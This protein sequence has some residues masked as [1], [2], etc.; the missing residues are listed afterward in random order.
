MKNKYVLGLNGLREAYPKIVTAL[1]QSTFTRGDDFEPMYIGK[2]GTNSPI[3]RTL[4]TSKRD[5]MLVTDIVIDLGEGEE[6]YWLLLDHFTHHKHDRHPLL[7][8]KILLDHLQK[9]MPE[10]IAQAELFKSEEVELVLPSSIL[11]PPP[12][13][14]TIAGIAANLLTIHAVPA[15]T[16][17]DHD[18]KQTGSEVVDEEKIEEIEFEYFNNQFIK[19]NQKQLAA[20]QSSEQRLIVNG[21]PGT[22]KSC[23]AIAKLTQAL[24]NLNDEI[25]FTNYL[26][27]KQTS[28]ILYVTA[29]E[30]LK[31]NM[32][33]MRET[34]P[35]FSDADDNKIEFMTYE[36]FLH[37]LNP[38]LAKKTVPDKDCFATWLKKY[39]ILHSSHKDQLTECLMKDSDLTNALWEEFRIISN[40]EKSEYQKIGSRQSIFSTVHLSKPLEIKF[41]DELFQLLND[42]RNFLKSTNQFDP[43]FYS[44]EA[45]PK[46]Y[47]VVVDEAQDFSTIQLA[48]LARSANR[49]TFFCDPNQSL[50]DSLSNLSQLKKILG[51]NVTNIELSE[52]LRC[53]ERVVQVANA[54]LEMKYKVTGGKQDKET[55]SKIT[56]SAN[57]K[58]GNT[59]IY[60][61][62]TLKEQVDMMT[63][64]K[65]VKC[66]VITHPEFIKDAQRKFPNAQILTVEQAK[67]LEFETVICF[68]L[69]EQ[70]RYLQIN[71]LL[72]DYQADAPA[73]Q[74]RAKN[75]HHE[76]GPAF[77]S[78]FTAFTRARTSLII[79]NDIETNPK[80]ERKIRNITKILQSVIPSKVSLAK[81]VNYHTEN[82]RES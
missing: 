66:A 19:L 71:E 8:K 70:S 49:I 30:K 80:L 67:G 51:D 15:S 3:I 77:N 13:T 39:W 45:T 58:R 56:S 1:S 6:H 25:E 31:D 61:Q 57:A 73:Q 20:L 16:E 48:M 22:G 34:S 50:F 10:L 9:I 11:L 5:R 2:K 75:A 37:N 82:T 54:L 53:S 44:F 35:S 17:V 46:F 27:E 32:Q 43:A 76:Y 38:E 59:K 62:P 64:I 79:Y 52:S 12:S 65:S 55:S 18:P 7:Q 47:Q 81:L 78:I 40:Y 41:R 29:S 60:S 36:E 72:K 42:Y 74:G 33:I 24:D 63:A 4:R 28:R 69:F 14:T 26:E 21:M 68:R 23:I